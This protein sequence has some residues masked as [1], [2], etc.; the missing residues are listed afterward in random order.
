MSKA[1][2]FSVEDEQKAVEKAIKKAKN[3]NP[4]S[5]S[6]MKK[7]WKYEKLPTGGISIS[8]YKGSDLEIVVPAKIGKDDVVQIDSYAFSPKGYNI[9]STYKEVRKKIK[10]VVIPDSVTIIK[11]HAF[12]E[13]KALKT[14]DFSSHVTE[15]GELAFFNTK[16]FDNE[17]NWNGDELSINGVLIAKKD[18]P[19]FGMSFAVTGNLEYYHEDYD[20][21]NIDEYNYPMPDRKELQHLLEMQGAKLSTSVSSKTN[22]LICNDT[23]IGTSKIDTARSKNVPIISE[24]EFFE[25]MGEE[26]HQDYLDVLKDDE[27]KRLARIQRIKERRETPK[28]EVA[29]VSTENDV[30]TLRELQDLVKLMGWEN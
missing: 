20:Y 5:V 6:E 4:S 2:N 30:I 17:K 16:F 11:D 18:S 24:E 12:Y 9:R 8:S 15:V 22:Y 7:I 3:V 1:T 25:L 29:E 13:C 28:T 23:G 14:V 27:E 19:I 10:S 26:M 21:Y